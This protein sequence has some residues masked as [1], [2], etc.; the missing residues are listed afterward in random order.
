M[1]VPAAWGSCT[2]QRPRAFSRLGAIMQIASITSSGNVA[3]TARALRFASQISTEL[4][5]VHG[6]EGI[7]RYVMRSVIQYVGCSEAIS[8]VG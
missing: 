6:S 8:Q 2:H 7:L 1:V 3:I 4:R 5:R